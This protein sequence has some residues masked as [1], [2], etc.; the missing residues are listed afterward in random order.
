VREALARAVNHEELLTALGSRGVEVH[1][2]LPDA[3]QLYEWPRLDPRAVEAARRSERATA[4]GA[5]AR[6][7]SWHVVLAYDADGAGAEVARSLQGQWAR[8]GH[9]AELRPLRGG[10]AVREALAARAAQA[11]LVESQALLTGPEAELALLVLPVRGPAVGGFRTGWR[12]REY[13]RWVALPEAHQDLDPDAVQRVLA[14]ERV[15]LPLATLPWQFAIRDAA[16]LP[17]VHPAF[18][19]GWT[20]PGTPRVGERSR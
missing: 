2:W 8:A 16:R 13:D 10:E 12:T 19:P 3:V 18:G 4:P 9:D 11:Q 5:R 6:R 17:V 20:G 15:V 7:A 14:E 1:R